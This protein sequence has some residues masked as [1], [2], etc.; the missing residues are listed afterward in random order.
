MEKTLLA[1]LDRKRSVI[2]EI[3]LS[4]SGP[5]PSFIDLNTGEYC[6]RKCT[7]CPRHDSSVYPN[8]DLYMS[9]YLSEKIYPFSLIFSSV[10]LK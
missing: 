9:V 1:N 3:N 2:D 10:L 6:N 8:Q 7:F 5:I 4:N